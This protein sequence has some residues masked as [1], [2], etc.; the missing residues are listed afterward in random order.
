LGIPGAAVGTVLALL[1]LLACLTNSDYRPGVWGVGLF[2]I[3]AIVYFLVY[4]RN[5]LVAQA[6]EE[7][8]ALM[9]EAQ[10]E[11]AHK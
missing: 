3:V 5:H 11:L 2:I 1:A 7:E 9:A 4:S 8:V 10:K 6:P